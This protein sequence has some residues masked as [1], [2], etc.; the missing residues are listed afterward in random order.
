MTSPARLSIR[1]WLVRWL[2]F[3]AT[4]LLF[5]CSL[6]VLV[7]AP[8]A[9]L[10]IVAILM[11]EWGHY[12]A[13][14]SV[15]FAALAFRTGRAG[16]RTTLFASLTALICLTPTF[17]ALLITRELPARCTAAFGPAVTD[18]KP[19][20]L[21]ALFCGV[22]SNDDV[23]TTTHEY[24]KRDRKSLKL[25]LYRANRTTAAQPLIVMVHGGSWNG[26]RKEQL[27]AI[28]RYLAGRQYA[29]ASINYRHA[30]RFPYPAAVED[31][32]AAIEFLKTNAAA[33]S[34]DTSRIALMGRSAGAQIAL[35]AAYAGREPAIR[36]AVAFYPPTDLVLGYEKPSRR[37]VLDSRK[38]LEDYLTGAPAQN[39]ERYAS[40]SPV[41]HVSATTPPTLLIHGKL[42]PIVWPVHSELLAARLTAAG[43]PHLHLALP[44]ATHGLDA[45][46]SGPSGQL[47]LYAIERLLAAVLRGDTMR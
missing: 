18:A 33:L 40:A 30:P 14:L 22:R 35:S 26:G 23:A 8:T 46:L 44:W 41:N 28:N 27:P 34:L 11:G 10:W 4:L 15:L 31:V 13:L 19:F 3:P 17:R 2:I 5:V 24:A 21:I 16:L 1:A 29:V 36:G 38:A 12:L 32:F 47:S 37:W 45:N 6:F 20:S 43:R 9:A 25:D 42:D 39:A 7:G